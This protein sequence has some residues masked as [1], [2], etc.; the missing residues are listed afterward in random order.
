[1]PGL[2]TALVLSV[3]VMLVVD[4]S[5][6]EISVTV[7]TGSGSPRADRT[8]LNRSELDIPKNFGSLNF[9]VIS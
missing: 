9:L 6:P 7:F 2:I 8:R 5:L 3:H 1:M 4:P